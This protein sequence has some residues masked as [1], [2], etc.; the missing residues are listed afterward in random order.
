M[1]DH[2]QAF[3]SSCQK[4]Y[5]RVTNLTYN[6]GLPG[7]HLLILTEGI[8][9]RN[10]VFRRDLYEKLQKCQ[11]YNKIYWGNGKCLVA[12]GVVM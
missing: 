2:I 5:N 3:Q 4:V 6:T 7:D 8:T 12:D 11:K 1:L 9:R 10:S